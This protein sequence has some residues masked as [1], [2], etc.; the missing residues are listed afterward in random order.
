M[1]VH[2]YI[3][4][5]Y[6]SPWNVFELSLKSRHKR[7]ETYKVGRKWKRKVILGN[8]I[9]EWM[10][11]SLSL[12]LVWFNTIHTCTKNFYAWLKNLNINFSEKHI[13]T[14]QITMFLFNVS[15]LPYRTFLMAVIVVIQF[16]Q[17]IKNNVL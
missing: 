9:Y 13:D 2:T 6:V 17:S 3:M 11:D 5:V 14:L 8:T 7:M 12:L 1:L 15:H 4:Y 10:H 16:I